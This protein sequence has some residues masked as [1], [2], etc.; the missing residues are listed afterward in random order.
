[1]GLICIK[2]ADPKILTGLTWRSYFFSYNDLGNQFPRFSGIKHYLAMLLDGLNMKLIPSLLP[3]FL[4]V[5][6]MLTHDKEI[7]GSFVDMMNAQGIQVVAWTVNDKAQ[8][9]HYLDSLKVPFL[10]DSPELFEEVL[11]DGGAKLKT[12]FS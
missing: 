2:K 5:E 8:M 10:T 4:G 1:M 3:R 9:V 6:M 11:A 12:D 7:S